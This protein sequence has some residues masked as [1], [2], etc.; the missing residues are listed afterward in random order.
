M[1]MSQ[2]PETR[3][4]IMEAL[5]QALMSYSPRFYPGGITLFR[6]S[7]QSLLASYGKDKGWGKLAAQ[8]VEIRF[9]SGNHRNMYE[10]PHAHILAEEMRAAL[11]V[12]REVSDGP[13]GAK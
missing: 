5:Y 3:R 4:R 7:A 6:T 13:E 10:E 9:V 2:L 11:K 12:I 1:D 8:G